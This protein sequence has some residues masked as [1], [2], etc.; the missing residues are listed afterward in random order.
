MIRTL[1]LSLAALLAIASCSSRRDYSAWA[2]I[3]TEGWAYGDTLRLTPADTSLVGNDSLVN[4]PLRLGIS[5]TNG[6]PYANLWLELT[7]TGARATYRDTINLR[8]ADIYGRWLGHGIGTNYQQEFTVNPSADIDLRL[9]VAVRHIMRT[10]TLRGI[11][12]IGLL[13]E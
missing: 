1:I 10:D 2:D 3:P 12:A 9:P 4:R 7:Y 13:V 6:Y 8:M 5:H 11:E